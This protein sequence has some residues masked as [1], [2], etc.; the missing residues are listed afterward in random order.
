MWS[1]FHHVVNSTD[2]LS[3]INNFRPKR[4]F[5]VKNILIENKHRTV[6]SCSNMYMPYFITG[7]NNSSKELAKWCGSMPHSTITSSGSVI[8]MRFKSDASVQER[9]FILLYYTVGDGKPM[10]LYK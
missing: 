5:P 1:C 9:G 2:T 3:F 6:H 10:L 7:I 4:E 8:S